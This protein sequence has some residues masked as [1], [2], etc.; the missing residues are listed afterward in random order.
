M[1]GAPLLGVHSSWFIKVIDL[2]QGMKDEVEADGI[3]H[4]AIMRTYAVTTMMGIVQD[5]R[6]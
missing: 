4:A 6:C 5:S 2:I 1:M 3:P